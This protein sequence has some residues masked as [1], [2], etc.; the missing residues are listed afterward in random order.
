LNLEEE[1]EGSSDCDREEEKISLGSN[2]EYILLCIRV[3]F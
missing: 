3:N 2:A 1:K